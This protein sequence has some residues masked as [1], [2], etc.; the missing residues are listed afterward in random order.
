M[1]PTV[2][3]SL[4][5]LILLAVAACGPDPSTARGVAEKFLDAHYV[6]IDLA[7]ARDVTTGVARHKLENE[8]RLVEGQPIDE[9]TRKPIVHYRL[10]EERPD[11]AEAVNY[12]YLGSITV[13][14]A[15]RFEQRW[16][17]TVRRDGDGWRVSNFQEL[18]S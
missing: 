11:G 10:L 5:P 9:T 3:A 8:M 6:R 1:R 14:D 13:A 4:S 16:L 2:V 15:D 12:L 17:V 18:G 7:A